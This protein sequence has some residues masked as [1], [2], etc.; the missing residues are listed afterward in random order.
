MSL[1]VKLEPSVSL[2]LQDPGRPGYRKCKQSQNDTIVKD[3]V[4]QGTKTLV[5]V[6]RRST[7]R[8]KKKSIMGQE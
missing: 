7:W 6:E 1:S 4:R 5:G 3:K 2:L 8:G